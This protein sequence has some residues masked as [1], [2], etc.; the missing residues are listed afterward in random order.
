MWAVP[1]VVTDILSFKTTQ[2]MVESEK[3]Q[4]SFQIKYVIWSPRLEEVRYFKKGKNDSNYEMSDKLPGKGILRNKKIFDENGEDKT[5]TNTY[6]ASQYTKT[7][8]EELR[9]ERPLS[10]K[11]MRKLKKRERN[12]AKG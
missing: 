11:Q 12:K 1:I 9:N 3:S 8:M 4:E 10:K 7:K 5:T 2:Q 6:L